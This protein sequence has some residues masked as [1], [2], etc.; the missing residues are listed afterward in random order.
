M[1]IKTFKFY[2]MRNTF[3]KLFYSHSLFN[4]ANKFSQLSRNIIFSSKTYI[5]LRFNGLKLIEDFGKS[6]LYLGLG[7]C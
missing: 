4:Q 2:S 5:V 3:S 6:V 1:A 7:L